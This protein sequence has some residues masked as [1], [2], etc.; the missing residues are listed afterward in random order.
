[1]QR[2]LIYA[3]W[4][5]VGLIALTALM[6]AGDGMY[7]RE[8]MAHKTEVDPVETI[9]IRPLY[10]VPRKDGRAELDFGDPE[11]QT[12]VH[13]L[14]PHLGYDPAGMSSAKAANR[15]PSLLY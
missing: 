6:W 2:A 13:S 14:F 9:K 5:L 10:V 8:R 11:T 7:V 4:T 1:M 12:C 15:S 3:K